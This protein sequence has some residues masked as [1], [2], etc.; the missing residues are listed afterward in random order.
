M[1][2]NSDNPWEDDGVELFFDINNDDLEAYGDNDFQFSFAYNDTEV[3]E[4]HNGS[5]EGVS[6][7]QVENTTGYMLEIAI[8]WAL[9]GVE[10]PEEGVL[11]GF[12]VAVN[13]DDEGTTTRDAK[14]SWH[15]ELDDAW[16]YPYLQ[17]TVLLQDESTI[18]SSEIFETSVSTVEIYPN[19]FSQGVYLSEGETY[20]LFNLHGQRIEEGVVSDQFLDFS[21]LNTGVYIL[22]VYSNH[23]FTSLQL[24]KE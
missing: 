5:V 9:L 11:H 24:V 7:V 16:Q 17:G 2:N 8:P 14:L 4:Y 3:V 6:F 22:K 13:D 19:P 10:N 15:S 1:N 20:E 12:D 18:T 23:S 21:A